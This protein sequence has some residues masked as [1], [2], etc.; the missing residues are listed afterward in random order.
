MESIAIEFET[1]E[2]H[3]IIK[4]LSVRGRRLRGVLNSL[5]PDLTDRLT[6][7]VTIHSFW[8]VTQFPIHLS[9]SFPT[10]VCRGREVA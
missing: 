6:V 5:L 10:N 3:F 1:I 4:R 9:L 8:F 7:S 2:I